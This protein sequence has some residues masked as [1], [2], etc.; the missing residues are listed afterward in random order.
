[1]FAIYKTA[2]KI[3]TN[4]NEENHLYRFSYAYANNTDLT[5]EGREI[6]QRG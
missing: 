2:I 4:K 5:K 3:F 1:M 6:C